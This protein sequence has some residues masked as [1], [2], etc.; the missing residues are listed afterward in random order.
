MQIETA[1]VGAGVVGLAVG[2]ELAARGQEVLLLEQH[3]SIGSESSSRNSE[4]LHAGLYSPKSWLKTQLCLEGK[5]KLSRFCHENNVPLLQ[6]GKLIVATSEQDLASL[7]RLQSQAIENGL[8]EFRWLSAKEALQLEPQLSCCGALFSP[9]TSIIDSSALLSGL[10]NS[11]LKCNGTLALQTKLEKI[12]IIDY[13][14]FKLTTSSLSSNS[15]STLT[16]RSLILATGLHATKT[17]S[18]LEHN[19]KES[20]PQTYFAKGHY[21]FLKKENPFSHLIYPLP[22]H[23]GLGIHFTLSVQGRAKFGPDVE[24]SATPSVKF[25]H[26]DK[27]RLQHF[28][29]SIRKYWPAIREE[30]LEEGYVGIRPR[31]YSAGCPPADF[32]IH[33]TEHHGLSNLVLLYGIESPGLT[34]CLGI[35][36]YVANLLGKK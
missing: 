33:G 12:E 8:H 25:E 9:T 31:L 35:A 30:M 15:M 20:I 36:A 11:F 22:S 7:K 16:C 4:V 3:R 23:E 6:C 21:Y 2:L 17:A 29:S 18:L 10:E 26:T 5:K 28:I 13:Q 32:A 1:V 19:L 24:W 34:S 27:K 14:G